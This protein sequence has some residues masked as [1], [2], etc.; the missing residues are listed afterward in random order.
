MLEA[1]VIDLLESGCALLAGFITHAGKPFAARGWGL[2][3]L[4]GG[5]T[6]RMLVGT[7][8]LAHLGYP[9]GGEIATMIAATGCS[10]LTLRSTQLK[11]PI[12]S[13]EAANDGDIERMRRYCDGYFGDVTSVDLIPRYLMERMV[14][15]GLA[16]CVFDIVEVYDQTPGPNAGA[17]VESRSTL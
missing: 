5:T 12:V 14:P 7:E 3:V 17:P 16:A 6:A 2:N 11:G 8:D 10:V 15:A 9:P 1:D 4:D 13:V